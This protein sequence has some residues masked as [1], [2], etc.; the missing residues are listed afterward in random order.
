MP[1]FFNELW[2][3]VVESSTKNLKVRCVGDQRRA[4]RANL[5]GSSILIRQRD[6]GQPAVYCLFSI[7]L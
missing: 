5:I 3:G 2:N 7:Y 1:V 4:G 6:L